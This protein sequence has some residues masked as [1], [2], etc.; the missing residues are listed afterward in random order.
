MSGPDTSPAVSTSMMD[1][2]VVEFLQLCA[3]TTEVRWTPPVTDVA[4][5]ALAALDGLI[6][7]W[8]VDR[9]GDATLAALARMITAQAIEKVDRTDVFEAMRET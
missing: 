8:L 5:F 1:A 2:E 7:R 4:R 3:Q 6:L 9:D